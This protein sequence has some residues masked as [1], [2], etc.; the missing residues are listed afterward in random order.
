[1]PNY[2]SYNM[3]I[4]GSRKNCDEF[5]RRL[6]SYDE[7]NHFWRIFEAT[8]YDEQV[9]D[10]DNSDNVSFSIDGYCAWSLE[11]CCRSSGY[12]HGIDLFEVN[13]RDLN[14]KMEAYSREPGL[15]F[16]EHYIYDH[17]ECLADEC[18]SIGVYWWDKDEY[19]TY[20]EY[21][22]DN[23]GAPPECEFDEDTDEALIGGFGDSWGVWTI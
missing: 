3:K 9:A 7:P 4:I 11:S 17:G 19:P 21:L 6:K 15:E 5:I 20:E 18:V 10:G 8:V 13:T 16:E 1:M 14:L 12:S 2:C 22:A 23:E